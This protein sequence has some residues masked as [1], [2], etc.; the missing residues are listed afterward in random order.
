MSS[1]RLRIDPDRFWMTVERSAEIGAG[2][3]GGLSRMALTEPDREM[4]DQ[5]VSWC[6]EAGLEV[7]VDQVGS[8]FARRRGQDDSL[9]PVLV[10]S[11]LDTQF[12]GGRFDGIVGVLAGLEI[13]R[14][15]N[16]AGHVTRRPIEIVN[17]TN[18]EGGRFPP[19]MTA[20]GRVIQCKAA[21]GKPHRTRL[22]R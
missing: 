22:R 15:L 4:R 2:R 17:W 14:T 19:P 6:R 1:S 21:L 16:D 13:V 8:I 18:E 9:P 5:F 10:G 11:H 7:T 20:S 3:E 12:N